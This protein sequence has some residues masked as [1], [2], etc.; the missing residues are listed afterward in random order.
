M[1]TV[2]ATAVLMTA[3]ISLRN[4]GSDCIRDDDG[5]GNYIVAI[6]FAITAAVVM[7][8]GSGC[9]GG[10]RQRHGWRY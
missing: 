9:N 3:A 1:E 7:N 2:A 8:N 4:I 5:S 10:R 6:V